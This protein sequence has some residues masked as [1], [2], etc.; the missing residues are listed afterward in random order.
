MRVCVRVCVHAFQHRE[1]AETAGHFTESALMGN[2]P[3][4]VPEYK[5]V[6]MPAIVKAMDEW[7]HEAEK[8]E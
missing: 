6:V 2:L 1:A 8:S 5:N 4:M 3:M 7:K